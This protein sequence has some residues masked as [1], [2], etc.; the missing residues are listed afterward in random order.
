MAGLR[1]TEDQLAA[2]QRKAPGA[3][4]G[5]HTPRAKYRNVKTE[6]AGVVY[7]SRKESEILAELEMLERAGHI[8]KLRRQVRFAIVVNNVHVCDYVADAVYQ[9][10]AR[11]VVLDVKSE[12][13]RKLPV[14]RL[15]RKLMAAA[16]GI[17]VEER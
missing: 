8:S 2:H 11:Q 13:T 6:R 1:W 5:T 4:V 7:D 10:G 14:Y 15:K 17:V 16:L 3:P 12:A 9:E